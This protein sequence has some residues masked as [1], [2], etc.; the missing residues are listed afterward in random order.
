MRISYVIKENKRVGM[1][2]NVGRGDCSPK[3]LQKRFDVKISVG[4]VFLCAVFI[5]GGCSERKLYS[6]YDFNQSDPTGDIYYKSL[7][8]DG[9]INPDKK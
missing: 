5:L 7:I 2:F 4:L 1:I 9:L 8:N 3:L 6:R